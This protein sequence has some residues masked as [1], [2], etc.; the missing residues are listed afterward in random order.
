ME[1][2]IID[3]DFNIVDDSN[4]QPCHVRCSTATVLRVA[5]KPELLQSSLALSHVPRWFTLLLAMVAII[6]VLFNALFTV[7]SLFFAHLGPYPWLLFSWFPLASKNE[8]HSLGDSEQQPVKVPIVRASQLSDFL[9]K[10]WLPCRHGL[11][12]VSCLDFKTDLTQRRSTPFGW[13]LDPLTNFLKVE[14]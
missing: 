14:D 5:C 1:V 13:P 7:V 12:W 11:W 10:M 6:I 4:C 2:M 8:S 9:P 3:D